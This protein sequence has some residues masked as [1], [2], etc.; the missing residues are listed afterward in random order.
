MS[1]LLVVIALSSL[2]AAPSPS[3]SPVRE[4]PAPKGLEA[5]LV[6]DARDGKLDSMSLLE[7]ALVA[8]GVPDA[9]VGDEVKRV[10]AA[11]APAVARVR[12]RPTQHARGDALLRALHETVFRR[13]SIGAT[14]V[15]GVART[16]EYNCLSSAIVYVVAA[17]GLV[18]AARAMVTRYHA[19]ARV[20]AD[21]KAV[22]VETTTAVGFGADRDALMTPEFVKRIAGDDTTPAEM[23][24]DLKSPE[25]LP[26]LSLVAGVYSNRAVGLAARGDLAA[27]TVALDRAARLA[28]GGLKS[29]SAAWRAGVLNDGALALAQEGRLEDARLLL[30]IAIEGTEGDTKKLVGQ[31]LASLHLK[32]ADD[33]LARKDFT[34]ALTAVAAAER[35]GAPPADV[36]NMRARAN[37]G[38]AALDGSDARCRPDQAPPAEAAT[39]LAALARSLRD[40]N[41]DTALQHARRAHALAPHD[42]DVTRSLFYTLTGKIKAESARGRCGSVEGLVREAAPHVAVLDGQ[43]WIPAEVNA[44]CWGRLADIAFDK[45]DWSAAS[46]LYARA[47]VHLPTDTA[48]RT[49]VAAVNL[50]RAIELAKAGSCDDARPF[51]RRAAQG[52]AALDEKATR[53]LEGCAAVRAKQAADARDWERAAAELRRGLR[54]APAS[55][56]LKQ[57]LA[58]M[59]HNVAAALLNARKCD[60]ARALLPELDSLTNGGSDDATGA[61]REAA[62]AIRTSCH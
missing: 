16:G 5:K 53:V 43:K 27:A 60:D 22:D 21:G 34:A 11:I 28:S 1:P 6:D 30:E 10:R 8:S 37:A 19:F 35:R 23:L 62:A 61:G 20:T 29:R 36:T 7:A 12:A 45:K 56:P 14:E 44:V 52:D 3:P 32:L 13:Y 38:L 49:N 47:L 40:S 24:A 55:A 17:E 58:T 25:E 50:N 15:D 31:N 9:D 57:N 4:V 39:C 18:D 2:A 33:A 46:S 51:A 26:L 48:F 42:D 41:V 54:D 59:L